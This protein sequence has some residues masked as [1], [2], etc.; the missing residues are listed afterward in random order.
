MTSFC[1]FSAAAARL[2]LLADVAADSSLSA[3]HLS[4]LLVVAS[5]VPIPLPRT[6]SLPLPPPA[7]AV[8]AAAPLVA[9]LE[10]AGAS[11]PS[12]AGAAAAYLLLRC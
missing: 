1:T 3:P 8:A 12:C 2:P 9:L 10:V 11:L 7:A 4:T 6:D 5:E